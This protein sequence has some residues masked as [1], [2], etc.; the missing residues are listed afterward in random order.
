M[1][2]K[3]QAGSLEWPEPKLNYKHDTK[4]AAK[5]LL[6]AENMKIPR[7]ARRR[8]K[9]RKEPAAGRKLGLTKNK[10]NKLWV[11]LLSGDNPTEMRPPTFGKDRN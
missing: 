8:R 7:R 9:R 5:T 1:V 2:W 10:N 6:S 3:S 4:K 11:C